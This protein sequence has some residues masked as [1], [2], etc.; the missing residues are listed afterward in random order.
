MTAHPTAAGTPSSGPP[1]LAGRVVLVTGAG[2]AIGRSVAL[3][4]AEAGADVAVLDL[5]G[6]QDTATE[7]AG[8]GRRTWALE[9]DVAARTAVHGAVNQVVQE[10]GRL[11]GLVT[12]AGIRGALPAP[13][14]GI[15][16]FDEAEVDQVIAVNL[17]GTLWGIQAAW[18]H[19]RARGGSIVAIG[20]L[21]GRSGISS[22]GPHYVASKGGVHALTKWAAH[23]GA[24]LGIRANAIAPGLI[25]TPMA[26]DLPVVPATPPIG[27]TGVPEDVAQAAL[28]LLSPQSNF[29]TGIVLDL[30]GGSYAA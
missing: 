18:P 2:G 15:E 13:G 25:Q 14:K 29:V 3:A 19:L 23:T 28:Y 9:V 8:P 11:D 22:A 7:L 5:H 16:A 27:R 4:C 6:A 30:N 1:D 24:A 10:A 17:K 20:S 12:A 26:H 21:A